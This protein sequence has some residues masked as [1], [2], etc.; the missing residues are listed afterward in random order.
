MG[1]TVG[2]KGNTTGLYSKSAFFYLYLRNIGYCLAENTKI[3]QYADDIVVFLTFKNIAEARCK[4]QLTLNKINI[5]L[6]SRRLNIS[7]DK[8]EIMVFDKHRGNIQLCM[9]SIESN[10]IPR[11][12]AVRFLGFYLDKHLTEKDY[13]AYLLRKGRKIVDIIASLTGVRWG[14]HS[15]ALL[16]IY[17]AMFCS[18]IEYGCQ[19]FSYKNN[20]TTFCKI[21]KCSFVR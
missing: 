17:R 21:Q 10:E 18:I 6:K 2:Q 14:A 16:T 11:V 13:F 12:N 1:F 19:I 7:P 3:L 15:Q 9:I 20:L 8:S 4:I 5:F